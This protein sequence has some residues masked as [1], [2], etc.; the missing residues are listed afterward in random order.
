MPEGGTIGE[1]RRMNTHRIV[2]FALALAAVAAA[3]GGTASA[4]P[5]L[6]EGGKTF[7]VDRTGERWDVT[8]A[9]SLG[10]DPRGFQYGIGRHAFT[11]L[12]DD[13]VDASPESVPG[14][15]RVIGVAEG[16]ESRAYSVPTLSRHEIANSRLDDKAIAA[17]Y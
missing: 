5:V 13:R 12:T 9:V 7:I 6:R 14:G 8:Q 2:I 16:G 3:A 4:A 11:P 17:G 10:F 1:E 15:L